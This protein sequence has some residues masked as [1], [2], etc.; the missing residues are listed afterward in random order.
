[1]KIGNHTY[2]FR[3]DIFYTG[4]ELKQFELDY[5][6]IVGQ[7]TIS[8]EISLSDKIKKCLIFFI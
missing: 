6:E 1:M 3:N 8:N 5:Q 2:V 4:E 7:I